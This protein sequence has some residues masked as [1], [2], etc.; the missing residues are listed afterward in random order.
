MF[1]TKITALSLSFSSSS[2]GNHLTINYYHIAKAASFC[3]AHFTSILYSELA[4]AGETT[5]TSGIKSII[6][7]AYR[8]IGQTDAALAFLDPIQE[9]VEY[10]E[11]RQNWNAMFSILNPNIMTDIPLLNRYLGQAGLYGLA[12]KLSQNM[13]TANYECAWRLSDWSIINNGSGNDISTNPSIEFDKHHYF[14]LKCLHEKQ[15]SGVRFN[16]ERAIDEVIKTMKQSSYECTK[17]IYKELMKLQ[18]LQQIEEF[19]EVSEIWQ[20]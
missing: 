15:E 20:N 3:N 5:E 17:N 7:T 2:I 14:A 16:I 10:F 6:K 4:L 13:N 1:H 19:C 8:S 18:M 11:M 12:N 9:R